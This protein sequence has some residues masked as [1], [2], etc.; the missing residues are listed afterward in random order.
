MM[1]KRLGMFAVLAV[2]LFAIVIVIGGCEEGG[3]GVEVEVE[4]QPVTVPEGMV[5]I[6]A[7]TFEMGSNDAEAD[8]DEQPVH[9][10]HLDAFY[11]DK[12]EVTNAQFKAFI[13][14]NPEWRKHWI[15]DSH[16]DGKY[17]VSW[18]G[19]DYPFGTA[20]HPVVE[21][22]WFAAMAYAK[23]A[24]KQLPTEAQW[25]YAAR[26]GLAGKKY[27]WGDAEPTSADANYDGNVWGTTPVGE[28]PANGYGLYDMAGNVKEWCSD[29]YDA[30]F[31]AKSDE[32]RNPTA[33]SGSG[34]VARGGAWYL[35]ARG[36]RVADRIG[37]TAR[38]TSDGLGFR[39]VRHR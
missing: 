14:E 3:G 9:T 17:L 22:S 11:M 33:F 13:D 39:C 5:L 23:W 4:V 30:D 16:H 31:Y 15:A 32:R 20:D 29:T 21:V 6:P 34:V 7:G 25:E 8:D 10:V 19:N 2:C 35:I 12:H 38:A 28:Y 1:L 36:L 26:G 24:E 18:V 27:P 37:Y